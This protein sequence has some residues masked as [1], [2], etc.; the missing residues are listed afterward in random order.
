[1]NI[2]E[3]NANISMLLKEARTI[4]DENLATS[5]VYFENS[6]E[7]YVANFKTEDDEYSLSSKN[8][9]VVKSMISLARENILKNSR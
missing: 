5:C 9:E 8:P 7:E 3:I 6:T 4:T 2:A 1:M